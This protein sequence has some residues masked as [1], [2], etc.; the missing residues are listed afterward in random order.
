MLLAVFGGLPQAC[1]AFLSFLSEASG[2]YHELLG[3]L[4]AR[5]GLPQEYTFL[6]DPS[7]DPIS[8]PSR[9]YPPTPTFSTLSTALAPPPPSLLPHS[10]APSSLPSPSAA[11]APTQQA[12]GGPPPSTDSTTLGLWDTGA[13][14]AGKK[15]RTAGGHWCA[16]GGAFT[17]AQGVPHGMPPVPDLSGGPGEVPGASRGG[18]GAGGE[19]GAGASS[20]GLVC[21]LQLLP[22]GRC[23]GALVRQ[24]PQSGIL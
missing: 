10:P 17:G 4:K 21:G 24:P 20:K 22:A 8:T 7:D 23:H 1:S 5:Q 14:N 2:F 16:R 6:E 9:Q 19:R 18:E 13:S 15:Q 12:S 3:K 11:L